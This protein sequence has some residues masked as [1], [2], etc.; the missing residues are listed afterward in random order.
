A[1]ERSEV[2][3]TSLHGGGDLGARN[4]QA[5]QGRRSVHAQWGCSRPDSPHNHCPD[6]LLH[7]DSGGDMVR[8][9]LWTTFEG[10]RRAPRLRGVT[11]AVQAA[12]ATQPPTLSWGNAESPW[13]P[14]PGP[15]AGR[16]QRAP[17]R[18]A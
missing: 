9:G 18:A 10:A 16:A 6:R 4:G 3:V 2:P 17:D 15:R 13:K 11:A 12:D 8:A 5:S 14:D 7:R 1:A